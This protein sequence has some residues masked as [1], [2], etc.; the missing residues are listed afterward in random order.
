MS[1]HKGAATPSPALQRS[2]FRFSVSR[3]L[4]VSGLMILSFLF[5]AAVIVYRWPS[6][7]SLGNAFAGAQ[8]WYEK[9]RA[10]SPRPDPPPAPV[11]QGVI[12]DPTRT[13]DG[14]TLY[15][16]AGIDGQNTH[17]YLMNMR[18]EVV[19]QWTARFSRIWPVPPHIST[20]VD[21]KEV[22]IFAGYLYP[23]GDLLVVFHSL[24][25][26]AGGL[27]L[28]KLDKD[29]NLLWK[30]SSRVHHDVDVG[31][32]GTIYALEHEG[33]AAPPK[34]LEFIGPRLVDRL[35][36][37]SP[38]GKLLKKIPILEALRD[39]PY[40]LLLDA[41]K[42]GRANYDALDALTDPLLQ[43]EI[44]Q[45]KKDALHTNSVRVLSSKLAPRFPAFKAGQ[46][47]VSLRHLD[48]LAVI[49]MEKG[50]VVWAS[51]GPWHAQHDAQF[52]DNGHLLLFDNLGAPTGSRVLEYDPQTQA[53]P[54]S[55]SGE[56][57]G[58]FLSKER[59]LCQRLPN[60]NTLIVDS[61]GGQ[62]LE[63]A[64]NKDVVWSFLSPA[65]STA[66]TGR[67]FIATA[68]RYGPDQLSF[69]KEGERA[70]P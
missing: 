67:R 41:L 42:P 65:D 34:G 40:A 58:P 28:A 29:S 54:W 47:L 25:R 50:A 1:A 13:F 21:D 61:D 11:V 62:L 17:I 26:V 45:R 39:S 43:D 12:D 56:N 3:L 57:Y 4:A 33:G 59:G 15:A 7:H 5:G 31:E 63:A 48:A 38:D 18:R 23:N 14:F 66:L 51:R 32:D 6:A 53:F 19:H 52:L 9:S 69:L 44:E 36:V 49:D 20:V 70:R 35:L 16:C 64:P 37:L 24:T 30:Y 68:R 55:Y 27:G 8:A 22:Y 10:S 46:V 60:G 2:F